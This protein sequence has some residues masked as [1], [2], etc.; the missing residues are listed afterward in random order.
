MYAPSSLAQLDELIDS[1]G[2]GTIAVQEFAHRCCLS[3]CLA[4]PLMIH[5]G[6]FSVFVMMFVLK[7]DYVSKGRLNQCG[8]PINPKRDAFV[9]KLPIDLKFACQLDVH[10]SE[11][12]VTAVVNH[13]IF[14]Q[15]TRRLGVRG[16]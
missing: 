8:K 13:K 6:V 7:S 14:D 15:S 4:Q 10:F 9:M 12:F 11:C 16:R 5:H 2:G 3:R 1:G